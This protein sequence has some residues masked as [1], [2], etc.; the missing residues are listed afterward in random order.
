MFFFLLSLRYSIRTHNL[1][2][3]IPLILVNVDN[4]HIGLLAVF[5]ACSDFILSF[6]MLNCSAVESCEVTLFLVLASQLY[7][8][9]YAELE[10]IF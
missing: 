10:G 5:S 4:Q 7:V 8:G 2:R 6:H 1:C 3:Y 9:V